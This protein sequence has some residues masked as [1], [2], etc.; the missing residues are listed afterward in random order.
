VALHPFFERHGVSPKLA[1]QYRKGG[2]IDAVGRGAFVRRGDKV[3]W[4]GAVYAL[5][6]YLDKPIQPGGRTALELQGD[7]HYVR[8]GPRS[9]VH[10]YGPPGARLPR[11][12]TQHDW[13]VALHYFGSSLLPGN[14]DTSG[15]WNGDFVLSLSS[16]ERAILEVLDGVPQVAGFDEAARLMEGLPS[17]RPGLMQKLLQACTSV[18]VKRLCLFLADATHMPWRE[19]INDKRLDLGVGKRQIVAGGRLDHRYGITVPRK[20]AS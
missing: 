17:L 3:G 2:W 16:P 15:K 13:G 19:A 4:Q 5:Q 12:F 8:L 20:F 11:W 6:K 7:A 18:K 9:Q 14:I 10:L 1:E